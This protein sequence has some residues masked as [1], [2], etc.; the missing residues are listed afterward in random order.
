[1]E[2]W[3]KWK[4]KTKHRRHHSLLNYKLPTSSEAV[5]GN[6]N[7]MHVAKKWFIACDSLE[8]PRYALDHQITS[9]VQSKKWRPE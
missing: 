3:E 2:Y 8:K 1:M 9:T 7:A 4:K 6:L 5:V